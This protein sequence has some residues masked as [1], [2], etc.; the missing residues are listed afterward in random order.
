MFSP[1]S[2]EVMERK[3]ELPSRQIADNVPTVKNKKVILVHPPITTQLKIRYRQG[4]TSSLMT[5]TRE[6]F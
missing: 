1:D 2:G 6:I 3:T 4:S 5:G